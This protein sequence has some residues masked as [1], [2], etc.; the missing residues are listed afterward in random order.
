M[1]L[2]TLLTV[3]LA[4][5]FLIFG[6]IETALNTRAS[7]LQLQQKV[8]QSLQQLAYEMTDKLDRGMFER[9]RDVEILS[10]LEVFRARPASADQQRLLLEKLKST[11]PSYAWIGLAS[12]QGTILASTGGLL[13]GQSVAQRPWFQGALKGP[14]AGD[15]HEAKLLAGLLPKEGV[16]PLRFVD[17]ATP[18][19]NRE[20]QVTGVLGAHLSWSWAQEVRESLLQ[21][22]AEREHLDIFILDR[23][24]T[25]LLG[26]PAL[27]GQQLELQVLERL[28]SSGY[29]VARWPDGR[30]YMTGVSRSRGYRS[31][32][33][34][35]WRVVV[36]QD[37]EVAFAGIH[38]FKKTSVLVNLGL[39]LLFAVLGFGAAHFIARPLRRL[40]QAAQAIEAGE[41]NAA[42]PQTR[43]YMEVNA[44]SRALQQ[45]VARLRQNERDLEQ[46][47]DDRTQALHARTK[48]AEALAALSLL[49]TR[50]LPPEE[51]ARALAPI[52]TDAC[53]LDWIGLTTGGDSPLAS[54][55]FLD[56]SFASAPELPH[57]ASTQGL[58]DPALA[59]QR[60]VFID[61]YAAQMLAHPALVRWGVRTAALLPLPGAGPQGSMLWAARCTPRP[62]ADDERRV[63]EAATRS[64]QISQERRVHLLDLELAALH[65]RLTG[66]GNRR[67]F[68]QC[69]DQIVSSA[70]R[71]ETPFGIIMIDLDGLKA[72]NDR[73][74][75]E[76]G[77][78]LLREFAASF[79]T[80]FRNEDRIFRLGGDEYAAILDHAVAANVR[81]LLERVGLAVRL[82]RQA[83]YTDMDASAGIAFFPEDGTDGPA[84][85]RLADERMYAEKHD[86]HALRRE[87]RYAASAAA[88]L[89]LSADDDAPLL[90]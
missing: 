44:L 59:P 33:G 54:T 21:P 50:T 51:L 66:L 19:R 82:T 27:Q 32:T 26:P 64:V 17:V 31:Y 25:V 43:A 79:R 88:V 24:G 12:V 58:Y 15:V 84:L 36:R 14:F 16:Q 62:W 37:T 67:A 61:N 71:H 76:R 53:P 42:V 80:A 41:L 28:P 68:D 20:G 73:E 4:G 23:D 74:G 60:P 1:Q 39:G 3:L 8:G 81:V 72:V 77:D 47:I 83:G 87:Q 46:R 29:T 6:S 9:S 69:L 38:A 7:S 30:T 13:E 48:E 86:H 18:V 90:L 49:A 85:T 5:L 63:F 52:I 89:P 11:Y 22:A 55:L 45:L 78:G 75:H 2:K 10:E 40:R 65:D 57:S 56:A 35:E 70:K 34:L